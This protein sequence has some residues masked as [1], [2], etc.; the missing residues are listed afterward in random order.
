M[1]DLLQE[2]GFEG[3]PGR[4]S[5]ANQPW[6]F[7]Q[8]RELAQALVCLMRAVAQADGHTDPREWAATRRFLRYYWSSEPEIFAAADP[9][10]EPLPP[11]GPQEVTEA[12]RQIR[13]NLPAE[14]RKLFLF[15]LVGIA[16]QVGDL[17]RGE[18]SRV[19]ELAERCGIPKADWEAWLPTWTDAAAEADSHQ[20]PWQADPWKIL[21]LPQGSPAGEV[22]RRY[23]QLVRSHHPDRFAHLGKAHQDEA[24]RRMQS[25]NVAYSRLC[26]SRS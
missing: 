17:L 1:R 5:A 13:E 9:G 18:Q 4:N 26:K 10:K 12:C 21:G 19:R 16:E 7:E 22:R 8:R 20:D 11:P 14:E 15:M 25:I 23:L 24:K 3:R 6:A 2:A